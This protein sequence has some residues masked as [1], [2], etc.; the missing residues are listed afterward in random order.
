[1]E[2]RNWLEMSS[3]R[4]I[5]K[6]VPQSQK[7]HSEGNVFHHVMMVRKMLP[8]AE[9]LFE[10]ERTKPDSPFNMFSSLTE[11]DREILRAAVWM[12]D[13]GK[14]NKTVY[15]LSSG[16]EIP[17]QSGPQ[18]E[19]SKLTSVGHEDAESYEPMMQKLGPVWQ[20]MYQK[21]GEDNKQILWYLIQ[22]HMQFHRQEQ[23]LARVLARDMIRQDGKFDPQRKFKL[24]IVFKVMDVMGRG[25]ATEVDGRELIDGLVQLAEKR[26]EYWEREKEKRVP[27]SMEDFISKLKAKGLPLDQIRGAVRGKFGIEAL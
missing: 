6:D 24:L 15:K 5:L 25:G 19:G 7:W 12:H 2:F 3:L 26:A 17:W 13:I 9:R 16:E 23:V 22:N 18:P 11:E 20:K 8:I 4:D 1:M 27:I 14:A 10:E 21:V